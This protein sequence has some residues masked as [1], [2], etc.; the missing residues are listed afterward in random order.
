MVKSS[1]KDKAND[2]QTKTKADRHRTRWTCKESYH[3]KKVFRDHGKMMRH[4]VEVHRAYA[5]PCEIEHFGDKGKKKVACSQCGKE[6]Q[7]KNLKTHGN[8]CKSKK[9]ASKMP[10]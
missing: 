8:S 3:C 9:S 10:S 6:V 7:Q 4:F 2:T 5:S 1:A